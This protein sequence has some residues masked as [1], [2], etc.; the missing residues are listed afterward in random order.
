MRCFN[1]IDKNIDSFEMKYMKYHESQD[2]LIF[3][4][5]A[6]AW[7]CRFEESTRLRSRVRESAAIWLLQAKV[8]DYSFKKA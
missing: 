1:I 3:N 2:S 8:L 4:I 6:H 5:L 7:S